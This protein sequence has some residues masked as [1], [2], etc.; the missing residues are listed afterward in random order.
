M[1][2]WHQELLGESLAARA[3]S[4]SNPA[5]LDRSKGDIHAGGQSALSNR[6][7][8]ARIVARN[9]AEA[10]A[11]LDPKSGAFTKLK[12]KNFTARLDEKIENG[13]SC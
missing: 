3:S 13:K 6:P 2:A 1:P 12:S 7:A 11:R 5:T 8:N 4:C 9:I 10:F